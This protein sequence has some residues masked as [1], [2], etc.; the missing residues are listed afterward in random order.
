[1]KKVIGLLFVV[2]GLVLN[3]NAQTDAKSK[4]ILAEVSKKYRSYNVLKAEFSMILENPS[5][6]I[7]ET[8]RGTLLA[9]AN[10]NK[11]KV[12][13]TNQ[14]LISDGV[15]QWTYL[16]NDKEV[17]ISTVDNS[18]DA[19]NPAKLFTIYEKGF[20][21]KFV[22]DA[23]QNGKAVQ[24]ITLTPTDSKKQVSSV[25][26]TIDKVAKQVLKAIIKD[27]SG[28]VYTYSVQKFTPNEKV[29]ESVFA[30]DVK[31]YPGVEVVDLR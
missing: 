24:V 4:A 21:S 20:N 22:R 10:T 23:T 2:F 31:K 16:K 12:I 9:K 1:M 5:A 25:E 27:K 18:A 11:Y 30:F 19:V 8:Q 13:M 17:Q 28:S 15:S 6:K 7:K 3:V 26:L 14:E 29:A